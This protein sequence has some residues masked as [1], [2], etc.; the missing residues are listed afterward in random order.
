M[1]AGKSFEVQDHALPSHT[2]R[3][4]SLMDAAV[5]GEQ[6][7]QRSLLL[8]DGSIRDLR[9]AALRPRSAFDKLPG[10]SHPGAPHPHYHCEDPP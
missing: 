9:G 6:S 8:V 5:L 3:P 1:H 4:E 2:K 10:L 7:R